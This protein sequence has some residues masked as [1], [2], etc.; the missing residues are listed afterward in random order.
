MATLYDSTNAND[1]PTTAKVVGGYVDGAYAWSWANWGRFPNA[2]W[3]SIAVFASTNNGFVLDVEDGCSTPAQAPGWAKMRRAAG[4]TNV[5]VYCSRSIMGE[6]QAAFNAANE[7]Q[8]LYWIA[9][10]TGTP[11]LVPG[12][13]ATQ[14]A[15]PPGSGG[16]YDLSVTNDIW[17]GV[18]PEPPK[19]PLPPNPQEP[20]VQVYPYSIQVTI[21][22]GQ[23][24]T[25]SPVPSSTVVSV[26]VADTNPDAVGAYTNIPQF[27]GCASQ[28]G[29]HTPSGQVL[30]FSGGANGTWAATCWST[31]PNK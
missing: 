3:V 27:R 16:H 21:S 2:Q 31:Q 14:Y 17:P 6:V 24:W 23:G 25:S 20:T 13:V 28:N 26:T 11:H 5:T 8:P 15:D 10:W 30:V 4:I 18:T 7:P 29:P 19:P 12:S 1:I 22:N 9:D